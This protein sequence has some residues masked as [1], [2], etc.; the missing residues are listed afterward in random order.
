VIDSKNT[1]GILPV[2]AQGNFNLSRVAWPRNQ[3]VIVSN[4]NFAI[5][6]FRYNNQPVPDGIITPVPGALLEIVIDDQP[7]SLSG[8]APAQ[9]LVYLAKWP[10][11][12]AL[13]RPYTFTTRADASGKFQISLLAAGDYR[14]V[15]VP[16]DLD[17]PTLGR[18]LS[19]A[20]RITIERGAQQTIQL[21]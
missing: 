17:V 3:I 15:A 12:A 11:A 14:A 18:L 5:K 6:E 21:K 1:T 20:P 4:P 19:T 9:S 7:A 13:E 2:D 10:F 16:K 8:T